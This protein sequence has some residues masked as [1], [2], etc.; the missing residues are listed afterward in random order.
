MIAP[1]QIGEQDKTGYRSRGAQQEISGPACC[2][3]HVSAAGRKYRTPECGQGSQE[4]VLRCRV[5]WIAAER[6][7]VGNECNGTKACGEL[8]CRDGEGEPGCV[9]AYDGLPGER[10]Y[11]DGLQNA[12]DPKALAQC[13]GPSDET[14]GKSAEQ[15]SG[16]ADTFENGGELDTGKADLQ[17]EGRVHGLSQRV[18]KLEQYD[19]QDDGDGRIARQKILEACDRDAHEALSRLVMAGPCVRL[20]RLSRACRFDREQCRQNSDNDQRSHHN[21]SRA[22]GGLLVEAVACECADEQ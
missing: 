9:V 22:I 2:I 5:Q 14:A 8:L 18:A 20:D 17:C 6:R 4:R 16:E 12:A 15:R 7:E 3:R 1:L 13:E 10:Q 19:E 11:R 21:I